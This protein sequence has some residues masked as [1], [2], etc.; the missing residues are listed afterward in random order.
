MR[1]KLTCEIYELLTASD[2]PL[3]C[4]S[5]CSKFITEAATEIS[6]SK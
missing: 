1:E 4:Y 3:V 2:L 6:S 5:I